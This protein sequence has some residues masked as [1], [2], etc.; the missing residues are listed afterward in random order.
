MRPHLLH[1]RGLDVRGPIVADSDGMYCRCM[2]MDEVCPNC[3]DGV[4]EQD[5]DG[6]YWCP[7]C[8]SS[9]DREDIEDAI[10]LDDEDG[11]DI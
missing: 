4:I 2:D 3:G 1:R 11:H 9:F 10:E 8:G 7:A 5:T 6:N